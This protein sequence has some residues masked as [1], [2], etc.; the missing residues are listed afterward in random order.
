VQ[1][2]FNAIMSPVIPN[3]RVGEPGFSTGLVTSLAGADPLQLAKTQSANHR[4]SQAMP[5]WLRSSAGL[6][7][8]SPMWMFQRPFRAA[9]AQ[10]R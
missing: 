7:A 10:L 4:R 9:S 5:S 1:Y 8:G 6:Y 2:A 3:R